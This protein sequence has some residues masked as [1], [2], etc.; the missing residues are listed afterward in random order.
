MAGP[1]AGFVEAVSKMYPGRASNTPT[2]DLFVTFLTLGSSGFK[3]LLEERRGHF[4]YLREQVTALAKSHG[5]RVLETPHN[6]I[7]IGISLAPL[8]SETNPGD[9]TFLGSMLFSRCVSG[10]RVVPVHKT[11]A[12]LGHEFRGFMAHIEGYPAPYLTVAAALGVTR[13][14]IDTFISRADKALSTFVKKKRA[15]L[16]NP[17]EPLKKTGDDGEPG[18]EGSNKEREE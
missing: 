1:D 6:D 5:T 18:G 9:I 4:Q 2:V 15:P 10:S 7:S 12:I 11:E 17:E 14:E 8:A 13:E 16:I 3:K